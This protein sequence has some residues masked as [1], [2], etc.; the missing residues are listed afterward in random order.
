[1]SIKVILPVAGFGKRMRPHTWSKPKP[2]IQVAG[3]PLLGHVLDRLVPLGI[4]EVV[5]I[6]GWLG[7]EI[8]TYVAANYAFQTHYVVQ[9]ELMGQAHAVYLAKEHLSGPCLIIFVDTVWG[10]D[11]LALTHSDADALIYVK[12]V[13][14]PRPFGIVE[15]RDG[16]VTRYVEKPQTC[17]NRKA[18]IG[19][20]YVREGAQLVG[21]IEHII[22]HDIRTHG[23][24]YMANALNVMIERGAK[25]L[26][27]PVDVW[28]D[29]GKPE[30]VLHTNRYLLENGSA[31]QHDCP[32]SVIIPPV[33]LADTARVEHSVVGPYVSLGP[34][35]T[36][37]NSVLRDCIVE[38][39]ALV[40]NVV[41][42]DSLIGE[43]VVVRG[44]AGRLN[45]GDDCQLDVIE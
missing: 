32:G 10:G 18:T 27:S 25:V 33:H 19:M 34:G 24:F 5:F 45:L 12:E 4:D 29:C 14:D 35:V 28:E 31:R 8:E 26:S 22:A 9:D 17:D 39:D 23:E 21:A 3:K 40:E 42:A 13:D 37:R 41:L 20:Y 1:L 2:L 6:T 16:Y 36:V 11:L 15:E 30:L 43:R 7:E 44:A 38:T